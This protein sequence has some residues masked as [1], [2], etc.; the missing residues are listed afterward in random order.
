MGQKIKAQ[1]CRDMKFFGKQEAY[2]CNNIRKKQKKKEYKK[3]GGN[4]FRVFEQME[5]EEMVYCISVN[6]RE[7]NNE[8]FLLF[9]T[10][11]NFNGLHTT[12][13]RCR[14]T[15]VGCLNFD[16]SACVGGLPMNLLLL[17]MA[18]G[19]VSAALLVSGNG[20]NNLEYRAFRGSL[21]NERRPSALSFLNLEAEL[22]S[23]VVM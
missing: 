8:G 14:A 13:F 19:V 18:I 23:G 9:F 4:G 21:T 11:L 15:T 3:F 5:C 20:E 10:P 2:I 12:G 7:G 16:E 6:G 1:S 22:W 17:L